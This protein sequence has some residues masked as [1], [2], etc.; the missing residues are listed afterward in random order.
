MIYLAN[1]VFAG[2]LGACDRRPS[3]TPEDHKP[4][5]YAVQAIETNDSTWKPDDIESRL[6]YLITF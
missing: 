4:A 1:S 6:R 3:L 5:F 2:F